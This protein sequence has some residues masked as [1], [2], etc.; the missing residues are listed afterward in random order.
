M[1]CL[2]AS[3][4]ILGANRLRSLLSVSCL[5]IGVAAVMVMAGVGLGAREHLEQ[6]L[7]AM[8]SN[9]LVVTAGQSKI[10]G[11]RLR[12][13]RP[14]QTLR[15]SDARAI[16]MH[17]PSLVTAAGSFKRSIIASY[18]GREVRTTFMALEPEGFEVRNL[19]LARGR[20]YTTSEERSKRRVL[21]LGPTAARNIFGDKDPLGQTVRLARQPFRVIGITASRGMDLGGDDQDNA[22]YLPLSVGASRLAELDHIETIYMKAVSRRHMAAAARE[23][24]SV[25]RQRHRLRERPDDFSIHSQLDLVRL[26]R[27]SAQALTSLAGTVAVLTWLMGAMGIVAVMLVAVRERRWEIGLRLSVGARPQDIRVQFLLEACV[28]AAGAGLAG[29]MLGALATWLADASGLWPTVASW[30]PALASLVGSLVL[31]LVCGTYPAWRASRLSPLQA[32]AR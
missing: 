16:R 31:G 1:P 28:L 18:K 27:D 20:C 9:L 12:R 4:E 2:E 6:R 13:Y 21:V 11:G 25:L 24:R 3:L 30:P 17:C 32:L 19:R 8:G 22:V 14:A 7:R 29:V 26:E 5:A 10:S 15:A 23:V